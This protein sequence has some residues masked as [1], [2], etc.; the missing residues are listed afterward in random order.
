MPPCI[1]QRRCD[2]ASKNAGM[3]CASYVLGRD[4]RLKTTCLT[5]P[6]SES[7][8]EY[9][10][11]PC[12]SHAGNPPHVPDSTKQD[13]IKG[14]LTKG[15][16]T[17]GSRMHLEAQVRHRRS[18]GNLTPN[19]ILTA[20]DLAYNSPKP[21]LQTHDSKPKPATYVCI[22]VYNIPSYPYTWKYTYVDIHTCIY[23]YIHVYIHIRGH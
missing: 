20:L 15:H 4:G 19:A 8:L 16:L 7:G 21:A 11:V 1:W 17:E 5:G 10:A 12:D 18:S 9:G 2:T 22:Y 13:Q 14:Q 6:S 3:S 23:I